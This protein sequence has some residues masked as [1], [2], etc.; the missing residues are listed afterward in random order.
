MAGGGE[1]ED[2]DRDEHRDQKVQE[3]NPPHSF[4]SDYTGRYSVHL[5]FSA[6]YGLEE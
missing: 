3:A 2:E 1:D 4:F 5:S 6:S